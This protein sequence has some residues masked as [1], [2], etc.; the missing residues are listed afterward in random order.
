MIKEYYL[1]GST[2]TPGAVIYWQID[3]DKKIRTGKIME[4]DPTTG[5]RSGMIDW[6]HSYNE[7]YTLR[8]CFFGEHL[9]SI[10]KPVAIVESEK[11]CP[12]MSVC[13]PAF[14]WIAAG[15]SNGLSYDKCKALKGLNVTLFPDQGKY[16]DWKKKA[17]EIGLECTI[18]IE[19][20]E[21]YEKGLIGKGEAID[22]YYLKIVKELGPGAINYNPVWFQ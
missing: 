1:C 18:S 20:E 8:Q 10:N 7:N 5:K 22:D 17:E 13:N 4:Y 9:I 14:T 6:V 15:G 11:A 3:R 19:A 12:I 2:K 21:W 16:H